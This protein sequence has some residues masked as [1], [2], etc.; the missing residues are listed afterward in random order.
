MPTETI[1]LPAE[2]VVRS[3]P[4]NIKTGDETLFEHELV[5][6]FDP[7]EAIAKE[8]V[9]LLPNGYLVSGTRLLPES[10]TRPPIGSVA[11]KRWLKMMICRSTAKTT[12]SIGKALFATDEF[13]N[14][15]FHWIGD[16]LPR[17]EAGATPEI[18]QRTFLVPAM[19]MFPYVS[20][21]LEPYGFSSVAMAS[22]RE[23]IR[24]GELLIITQAAPTGNYRPSLMKSL[25]KRFRDHF[26]VGPAQRKLYVSRTR[27]ARR[28]V[29]NEDH[30]AAV[31]NRHGFEQV[32]LEDLSFAEQVR[33]V[34][35]ASVLVGNHGAGL[36]NMTWMLPGTTVLELR[37]RGD[38]LNNCYFSLASALDIRYRYL[39]CSAAGSSRSAHQADVVVDAAELN[40]ELEVLAEG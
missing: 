21:S 4:S 28:R 32:F 30:V 13:S 8:Q 7:M 34:G 2:R 15:F 23:T 14:G 6:D 9:E 11:L 24:C 18:R 27:A 19:A 3:L 37:L 1:I 40:H 36:A 29:A 10:F 17:L 20:P 35:S 39:L 33:R 12:Q 25:R 26:G 16:V 22:W 5:R 31:M 38:R